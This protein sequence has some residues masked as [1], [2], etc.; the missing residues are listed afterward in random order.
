M[1]LRLLLSISRMTQKH[2]EYGPYEFWLKSSEVIWKLCERNRL[3]FSELL[4][5]AVTGS[6]NEW[7]TWTQQP[8]Q[9]DLWRNH[10][11]WFEQIF[12]INLWMNQLIWTNHSQIYQSSLQL[13]YRLNTLKI[14]RANVNFFKWI[15]T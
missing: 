2:H 4:L 6:V 7:V 9:T 12:Q 11:G 5:S 10:S 3:K 8:D 13:L 14:T 15:T 1:K